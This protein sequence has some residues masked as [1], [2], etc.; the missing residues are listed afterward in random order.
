MPTI[1][2]PNTWSL[3]TTYVLTPVTTTVAP[4]PTTTIIPTTVAPGTAVQTDD[5]STTVVVETVTT[6]A[7]S[8]TDIWTTITKTGYEPIPVIASYCDVDFF[9]VSKVVLFFSENFLYPP[10][11]P[12]VNFQDILTLLPGILLS[13]H[14]CYCVACQR[15]VS[16][17]GCHC[18]EHD[19]LKLQS[20]TCILAG[21]YKF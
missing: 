17:M 5:V 21:N 3:T 14:Y 15:A 19:T 1:V 8:T 4:A 13:H 11:F 20:C 18:S 7:P 10:F 16:D 2:T 12:L 9:Y 6:Y